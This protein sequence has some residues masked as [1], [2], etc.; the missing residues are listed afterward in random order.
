MPQWARR[1]SC[2]TGSKG[3]ASLSDAQPLSVTRS[4]PLRASVSS[5][6]SR[7]NSAASAIIPSSPQSISSNSSP[8]IV[9]GSD[10]ASKDNIKLSVP[11]PGRP[12]PVFWL[13]FS[14]LSLAQAKPGRMVSRMGSSA[15]ALVN[16]Q[17][18]RHR[19]NMPGGVEG[20]VCNAVPNTWT[21]PSP[22]LLR[23]RSRVPGGRCSRYSSKPLLASR[24]AALIV[25]S[26]R[27]RSSSSPS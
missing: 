7:G 4:F 19:F 20:K 8:C 13:M 24:S 17:Q 16:S 10:L 15:A 11:R 5:D 23:S 27:A 3:S 12:K 26:T 18:L 25:L 22:S 6:V 9:R 21:P 14:H 2:S 1:R